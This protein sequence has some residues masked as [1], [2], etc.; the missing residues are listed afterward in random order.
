M[1]K[2]KKLK[3]NNILYKNK[4]ST[5]TMRSDK[6]KVVRELRKFADDSYGSLIFAS[7]MSDDLETRVRNV[8]KEQ[9]QQYVVNDI[10]T[11]DPRAPMDFPDIELTEL[12]IALEDEFRIK[13][14]EVDYYKLCPLIYENGG[15]KI[16]V[17]DIIKLVSR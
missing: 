13:I 9:F 6:M 3:K 8:I 7:V 14:D 1:V 12:I 15:C 10:F 2:D 11:I 16:T 17:D 5:M 4:R